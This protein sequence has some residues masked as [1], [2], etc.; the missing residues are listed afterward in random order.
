MELR[1]KLD[2]DRLLNS[3]K[4][5][6]ACLLGFF[7]ARIF[8]LPMSAWIL[9][10]IIVVMSAQINVGGVVIKSSMQFIGTIIGALV[11][12]IVLVF[13]K[14]QIVPLTCI[15][16]I[17]IFAFSYIASNQRET[18]NIGLLGATTIIMIL[19]AQEPTYKTALL[20]F[21]EIILGVSL[22]FVMSKFVFPI[23]AY[24]KIYDNIASIMDGCFQL[25]E[26]LWENTHNEQDQFEEKEVS[27][28]NVFAAQRKLAREAVS[29][30]SSKTANQITYAKILKSQ[31]EIFRYICLM[32]Q[33]L[34]KIPPTL[35]LEKH[36]SLFNQ[37]VYLWL[38]QLVK[39][40]KNNDF[41]LESGKITNKELIALIKGFTQTSPPS[42]S[43]QLALDAFFFCA[44]NLVR[45]LR[46]LTRLITLLVEKQG[47][48][49]SIQ[50]D[51]SSDD[52]RRGRNV[53]SRT[54]TSEISRTPKDY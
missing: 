10:T 25:Y 47:T 22:A 46:R 32:H 45:E 14:D 29:E 33:A 40:L 19:L 11:S 31:R 39:G 34:T 54:A 13:F 23:H 24:Q 53:K 48:T 36:L 17:S 30:L 8:E 4:T 41:K 52:A 38:E 3:A 9:I 7:I 15:L 21:L 50:H 12:G 2:R 35:E 27:I 42:S 51:Q 1:L 49:R 6:V 20:R 16:F 5:A 37:H 44:L 26:A 43:Q 28:I 18:S